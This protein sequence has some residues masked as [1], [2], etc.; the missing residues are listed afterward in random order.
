VGTGVKQKTVDAPEEVVDDCDVGCMQ[1]T[2][3]TRNNHRQNCCTSVWR[4]MCTQVVLQ[5]DEMYRE[6]VEEI[7]WPAD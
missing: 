5:K 6:V 2:F 1:E 3:N 7:V 4:K